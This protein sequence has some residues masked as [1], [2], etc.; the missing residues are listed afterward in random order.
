MQKGELPTVCDFCIVLPDGGEPICAWAKE[1]PAMSA[2][3]AV[4]VVNVFIV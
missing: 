4:K 1:T 3:M 2:A